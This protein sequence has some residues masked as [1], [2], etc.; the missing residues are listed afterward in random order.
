M[1][2]ADQIRTFIHEHL[3]EVPERS[4]GDEVVVV[5]PEPG[6]A[7]RSG[8][9]SIN[10]RSGLTSCW[11][12]GRGGP[13]VAWVRR[14]GYTFDGDDTPQAIELD[15]LGDLV[16]AVDQVG[17]KVSPGG[18]VPEVRLPAGFTRVADEPDGVYARLIGRMA[19]RKQL[20][21]ADLV[22]AGVGF[23]RESRRWERFAIFPVLEWGRPVYYQGRT[24]TDVPGEPT[25]QFPTREEC[26]VSSRYWV[27]NLD[28]ARERG[29]VLVVVE[30]ILNVL[31]F[32]RE[33]RRR[34]LADAVAVAVFKHKVSQAQYAKLAQLI[35]QA[36]E[37]GHPITEVCLIYDSDAIAAAWKDADLFINLVPTSVVEMPAGVDV[38]DDAAEAVDRFTRRRRASPLDHL[39][40]SS[41]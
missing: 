31:S 9:R 21:L 33:A 15:E 40:F 19:A 4:H 17:A 6:C 13:F 14:L 36:G 20:T 10:L 35:R 26:P 27:Y 39:A 29:G 37:R 11:R 38:N 12:C 28:Q 1:A 3:E 22:E 8:N 16:Q 32:R 34:G 5:C 25:K 23:T 2:R 41:L 30:S 18:Y 7:D 24:Y